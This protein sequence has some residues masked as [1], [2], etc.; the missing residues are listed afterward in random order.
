MK[1]HILLRTFIS[2]AVYIFDEIFV[3]PE[4]SATEI[5]GELQAQYGPG[6]S[7]RCRCFISVALEVESNISQFQ[8][9][10]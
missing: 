3:R 6:E 2:L 9:I 5:I 8:E 7:S 10:P 4:E 1:D